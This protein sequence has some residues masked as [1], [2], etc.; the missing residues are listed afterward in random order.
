MKITYPLIRTFLGTIQNSNPLWLRFEGTFIF[1]EIPNLKFEVQRTVS[2]MED[3]IKVWT[4]PNDMLI[5]EELLLAKFY[6]MF[7]LPIALTLQLPTKTTK[8]HLSNLTRKF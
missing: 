2:T 4:Q 1:K 7:Q 6:Q 3:K 5:K 8:P